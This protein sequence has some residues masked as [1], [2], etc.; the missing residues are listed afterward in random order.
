MAA[1]TLKGKHYL[2]LEQ[3]LLEL[4]DRLIRRAGCRARESQEEMGLFSL[5][6]LKNIHL[7]A[8]Q[9]L[10]LRQFKIKLGTNKR[11]VRRRN[12][13]YKSRGSTR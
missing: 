8:P 6:Y 3:V 4:R 5:A 2:V 10:R 13:A 12:P 1:C 7:I 9:G 11:V